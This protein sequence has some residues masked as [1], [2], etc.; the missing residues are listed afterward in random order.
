LVQALVEV[1]QEVREVTHRGLEP[2]MTPEMAPALARVLVQALV[3]VEKEVKEVTH[4]GLELVM[5]L[6]WV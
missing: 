3:E 6:A 1:E 5:A 2:V 4:W